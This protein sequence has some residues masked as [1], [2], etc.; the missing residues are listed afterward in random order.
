MSD[1][2]E[3]KVQE[4]IKSIENN[5]KFCE[6]MDPLYTNIIYKFLYFTRKYDLNI[7]MKFY[8]KYNEIVFHLLKRG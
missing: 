8:F 4:Y 2:S 1:I 7:R 3:K 6:M 5:K